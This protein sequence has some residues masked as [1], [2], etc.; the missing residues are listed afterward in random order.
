MNRIIKFRAYSGYSKKVHSDVCLNRLFGQD[1][2]QIVAANEEVITLIG[3]DGEPMTFDSVMQYTGL[4]DKNGKEIYEG[5]II[6]IIDDDD[7]KRNLEIIWNDPAAE[8]TVKY[9]FFPFES[10]NQNS[11]SVIGN[12][13]ENRSLLNERD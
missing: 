13:F 7:K 9:S 1:Y 5:D 4:K 2:V 12:I 3:E 8:F 6:E 11:M 10:F